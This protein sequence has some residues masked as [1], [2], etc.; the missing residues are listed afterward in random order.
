MLFTWDED[1]NTE[2]QAKHDGMSFEEVVP[3]LIEG[4]YEVEYDREQSTPDEDRFI[5]SG[6]V[7]FHGKIVVVFIEIESEF[8]ESDEVRII[9]SRRKDAK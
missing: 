8:P 7:D 2:N 6:E 1:K 5:A 4:G 9:S 3:V